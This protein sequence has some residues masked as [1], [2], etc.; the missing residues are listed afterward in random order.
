M[1]KLYNNELLTSVQNSSQGVNLGNQLVISGVGQADDV[2]LCSN[3]VYQL[4]NLLILATNYCS[5]YNVK[6]CADKTKLM[7]IMKTL[8]KK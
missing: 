3:N 7:V 8:P 2:V 5:K 1:Y 4:H 6:L